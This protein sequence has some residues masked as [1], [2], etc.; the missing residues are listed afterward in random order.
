MRHFPTILR[1]TVCLWTVLLGVA[2]RAT[3]AAEVDASRW[4]P[5]ENSAFTF[6]EEKEGVR[7]A[8]LV[9]FPSGTYCWFH[10]G[11][12]LVSSLDYGT[13]R[14]DGQGKES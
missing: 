4:R 14:F 1:I 13:W 2:V 7:R 11:H 10:Y 3:C 9:F 8:F 5:P 6:A 12:K